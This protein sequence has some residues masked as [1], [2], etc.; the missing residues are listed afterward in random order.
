MS[1]P[2]VTVVMNGFNGEAFL[3]Q[4]IESVISQTWTNWEIVFWD[5]QSTDSSADIVKSYDDPR[6]YYHY[7]PKH[8]MLYEA[9]NYAIEKA[10]GE[11]LAFLDVDD[12]WLPEKLEQQVALFADLEVSVV[13][14]N[15][16]VFNEIKKKRWIAYDHSLPQGYILDR[17][18]KNYHVGLLTLMVRRVALPTGVSPFDP[19]FHMIGDF[20]IVLRLAAIHKVAC[21]QMPVAVYRIHGRNETATRRSKN[22]AELECWLKEMTNHPIIGVANNFICVRSHYEYTR[23]INA[24]L[25]GNRRQAIEPLRRLRWGRL[26]LKLLAA[27]LLPENMLNKLKN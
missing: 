2:L 17:L 1:S 8:T 20:D 16:W 13:Y 19:R 6:I 22:I 9:R 26:K 3:R 11:F 4:A 5:N 18:L 15:F 12:W 27:F 23:A 7:A 21:I 25:D 24:L 10:K 14:G